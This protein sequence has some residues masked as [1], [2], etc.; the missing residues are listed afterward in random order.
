MRAPVAVL[1]LIIG[2]SLTA[3]GSVSALTGAPDLAST[4]VLPPTALPVLAQQNIAIPNVKLPPACN[5]AYAFDDASAGA[6][7]GPRSLST[8]GPSTLM[9]EA[10]YENYRNNCIY[11]FINLIDDR[12]NDYKKNALRLV[13]TAN[14]GADLGL[15]ATNIAGTA[16]G[17]AGAK[18]ILNGI[19]AG[20]TGTRAAINSD[21][22][23]NTTIFTIVLQMDGDR[24]NVHSQILQRIQNSTVGPSGA[25]LA[26]APVVTGSVEKSVTV[27]N[28]PTAG[29]PTTTTTKTSTK[30]APAPGAKALAAE[31]ASSGAPPVSYTM[32]QAANDLLAYYEA[33]TW[34]HA[35]FAMQAKA[36]TQVSNCTAKLTDAK[37][38][39][40]AG[41][42]ELAPGTAAAPGKSGNPSAC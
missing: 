42:A 13:D 33:G 21:V 19:A 34:A 20:I 22:L 12:Y 36:G 5:N 31:L 10:A 16:V 9:T 29:A 27:A 15:L 3:C 2:V 32:Y 23:Y 11:T 18:T 26:A 38:N 41:A 24:A 30:I 40:P 37:N 14:L 1:C 35:M 17:G 25:P 8:G 28:P 6:A 4:T 39:Q 7:G